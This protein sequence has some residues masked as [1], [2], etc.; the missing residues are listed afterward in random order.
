MRREALGFTLIELLVVIALIALLASLL[1]PALSRAQER[2]KATRCLSNLREWNVAL[3]MYMHDNNDAIPR[4]GQG[5]QPLHDIDRTEDWFNLLPPLLGLPSYYAMVTNSTIPQ[6]GEISIYVCP[7]ALPTTNTYFLAYAMNF[8]LSPTLR[9]NPHRLADIPKPD[10]LAFMADGGCAYSSTVPS[11][12]PY[13]VQAR[14]VQR[15]NV[16]F[17]DGH[18]QSFAGEYLGC[19]M[20][21]IERADVRWQTGSEGINHA[22]IP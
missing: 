15:A 21:A 18:V 16:S 7:T 5:V 3:A 14:H 10:S 9:P 17:L 1:L 19:G 11:A 22:P 2:S 13:S 8:Y 20:G 6:P 12:K 4:R